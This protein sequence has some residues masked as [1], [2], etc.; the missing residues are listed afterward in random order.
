MKKI[1]GA[2]AIILI[3]YLLYRKKTIKENEEGCF[4]KNN[5]TEI[6]YL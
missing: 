3:I 2:S 6:I 1:L 5:E 4:K